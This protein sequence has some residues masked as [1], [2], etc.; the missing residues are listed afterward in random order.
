ML[1]KQ[2]ILLLILTLAVSVVLYGCGGTETGQ[3]VEQEGD[4]EAE[5]PQ[6]TAAVDYPTR[7]I[8]MVVGWGAGGGTDNFARAIAAELEDLLGVTINVVNMEGSSEAVA[9]M[10]VQEQPADGYTLYPTSNYTIAHANG[11]N[12]YGLDSYTPVARI[13][14][15]TATI[16]VKAGGSFAT[17]EELIDYAKEN[18]G[19]VSIGGTGAGAFDELTVRRFEQEAGIELNYVPFE[20]AGEMHAAL[21]G[22]HIDAQFEEFGPTID[23]IRTEE[24]IPLVVFAEERV[25]EFPDIP[26]TVEIGINLTDGLSRGIMVHG[27]TPQEIVE[28]LEKALEEAKDRPGYKEYEQNSFLH[29]REGWLN[30]EDYRALL[31]EQIETYTEIIKSLEE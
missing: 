30:A 21:L 14:A 5:G 3:S 15:D 11:L 4:Q 19:Q 23:Y 12:P 1:K 17:I 2:W 7:P 31:A 8:E 25:D 6:D 26:T 29:L 10:Y 24:I 28:I 13:Q 9:G 18:P 16:Q 27:D 22:G 20:G